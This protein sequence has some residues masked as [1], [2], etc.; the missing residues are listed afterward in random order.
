MNASAP[1]YAPARCGCC[2]L[3]KCGPAVRVAAACWSSCARCVRTP[4]AH[5]RPPSREVPLPPSPV[6]RASQDRPA[7][8]EKIS[9]DLSGWSRVRTLAK[10]QSAAL[11]ARARSPRGPL[12]GSHSRSGAAR[13]KAPAIR[14]ARHRSPTAI[15]HPG[16]PRKLSPRGSSFTA[17]ALNPRRT[18]ARI[19]QPRLALRL[20]AMPTNCVR[21]RFICD[22]CPMRDASDDAGRGSELHRQQCEIE[23]GKGSDEG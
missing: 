1:C 20:R 9:A 2:S 23:N 19:V 5:R 10:C 17:P 3:T 16:R 8:P 22:E 4:A 21:R 7:V 18:P 6:A 11:P 15:L 13:I 14:S 12:P